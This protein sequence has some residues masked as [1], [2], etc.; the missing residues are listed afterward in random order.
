[1]GCP[2][3]NNKLH[4]RT[5]KIAQNHT[6][7]ISI[8]IYEINYM[9]NGQ[10]V[11]NLCV[12][13]EREGGGGRIARLPC[14]RLQQEQQDNVHS[15]ALSV[16]H[17]CNPF[18]RN[19]A[20]CTQ[21]VRI[22]NTVIDISE[23][24]VSRQMKLLFLCIY[25]WIYGCGLTKQTQSDRSNAAAWD[26]M[27]YRLAKLEYFPCALIV[28]HFIVTENSDSYSTVKIVPDG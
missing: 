6:A 28:F 15:L 4:S 27:V 19:P 11:L 1:M 17:R 12:R 2:L 24:I 22:I 16:R 14:V 26:R 21:C 23:C 3:P 10:F 25:I 9:T 18:S 7:I 20:T 5:C 13:G 8:L